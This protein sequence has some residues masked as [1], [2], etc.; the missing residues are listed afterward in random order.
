LREG[1]GKGDFYCIRSGH[2]EVTRVEHGRET[3]VNILGPTQF[4]GEVALLL[5]TARNATIRALD[6]VQLWALSPRDFHDLLGHYFN[7]ELALAD[8]ARGRLPSGQVLLDLSHADDIDAVG[9]GAPAPDFTLESVDGEPRSLAG[10]RGT[11]LLLWFSP[12]FSDSATKEYSDRLDAAAP[13]FRARG[14]E[15]VQIVPDAAAQLQSF[16]AQLNVGHAVL[17]DPV[18]LAYLQYGLWMDVPDLRP[19]VQPASPVSTGDVAASWLDALREVVSDNAAATNIGVIQQAII[20]I[21]AD[22]VIRAR[23][24]AGPGVSL[25]TPEVVLDEAFASVA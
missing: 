14:V 17:C 9:I 6:E 23:H 10:Y 24:I 22:G 2:V 12:G 16:M 19:A 25:P 7:L 4:F 20:L 15:A 3:R 1:E 18:K 5:N 8:V 21:D 13:T 11:P